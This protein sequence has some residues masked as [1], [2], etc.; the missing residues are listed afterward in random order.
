MSYSTPIL[1]PIT[2]KINE[3]MLRKIDFTC[4]QL[5]RDATFTERPKELI[6]KL[7]QHPIKQ[8]T[9]KLKSKIFAIEME[10]LSRMSYVVPFPKFQ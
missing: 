9:N 5:V 8:M 7:T 3:W 1:T 2:S 6:W 10:R 4:Y